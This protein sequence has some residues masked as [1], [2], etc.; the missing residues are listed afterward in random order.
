[1]NSSNLLPYNNQL[2]SQIFGPLSIDK[3][4]LPSSNLTTY[5]VPS[6]VA[7]W[8]LDKIIPGTGPITT[9]QQQ[10]LDNFIQKAFPRKD[11]KEIIKFRLSQG[12]IVKIIALMQVRINL[13]PGQEEIPEPTAQIP[14]LS[15]PDIRISTEIVQRHERLLRQGIWGKISLAMKTNGEIEIIDF[16]PF[17]YSTVHLPTYSQYRSQLNTEQWRDLMF[18]SMGYNP[19]HP[20]YTRETKTW[21]LARL[22]PLVEPNYHLWELAPKGT[23]KSFIFENLS[24]KVKLISGGKIGP[25]VLFFNAKTKEI[26][27]LGSYDTVVLDEVQS[28]YFENPEEM[29]GPLKNYL[30]NGRYNRSGYADVTSDCSFVMLANIELNEQQKPKNQN[31]LLAGLPKFLKETA[32]LDRFAGILPGWEIPKF[33]QN[34]IAKQTG[35]KTDYFAEVLLTLRQDNRFYQYAKQHT[36]FQQKTITIRDQNAILK[37]A[38]GL[39]KILYP[40]LE[41]TLQDY[42]RD[43]LEPAVKMRQQIRN[44]QYHSDEEFKQYS[45]Q[46]QSTTQNP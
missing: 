27:L 19:E 45:P 40:H 16:D 43:C 39:L 6:F 46:I 25:A 21:I 32:F 34:M 9:E 17:Q 11:D 3:T 38:S 8:L 5:G 1:M 33:Q 24:S 30:A 36:Y 13:K 23:G 20:A 22:L 28:L 35:L 4:R 26:G 7:E 18:C 31:N 12:E 37:T 2:I 44:L 29:I 15:F 14:T 42:E 10:K 41:L